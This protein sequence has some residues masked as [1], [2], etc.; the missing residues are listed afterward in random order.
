MRTESFTVYTFDELS[1]DAKARA[2][3]SYRDKF[4]HFIGSDWSEEWRRSIESA[5]DAFGF[6]IRDWSV[7]QFDYS[8]SRLVIDDLGDFP[9][10]PSG[11]R[12]WKYLRNSGLADRVSD[13]CPWTGY[14][15]DE[16]FLD[17]FRDFMLRPDARS[18]GE[19]VADC[20]ESFFRVWQLDVEYQYSDEAIRETIEA[21]EYEFLESGDLY[22]GK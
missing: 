16:A 12:L 9:E 10:N 14:C 13:D 8:F 5:Q 6:R 20:V 17:P 22:F 3:D 7:N 11:V 2:L 15:G 1:D 19:L 21:N 18:W 4:S